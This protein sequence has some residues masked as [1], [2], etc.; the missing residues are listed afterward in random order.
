VEIDPGSD[1]LSYLG[2]THCL[3]MDLKTDIFEQSPTLQR[4]FSFKNSHIYKVVAPPRQERSNFQIPPNSQ[5]DLDAEAYNGRGLAYGK[6]DNHRQETEDLQKAA[7]LG[8][9]NTKR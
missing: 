2:V 8:S 5:I 3:V 1:V 7:R 4:L 9:E 6:L